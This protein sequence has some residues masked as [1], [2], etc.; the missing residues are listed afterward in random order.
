MPIPLDTW[1]ELAAGASVAELAQLAQV[2]RTTAA[3]WRVTGHV[4]HAVT[5]LARFHFHGSLPPCAGPSWRGWRFCRDG[6]LYAPDLARGFGPDEIRS[7]VWFLQW[8]TWRAAAAQRLGR[9][10]IVHLNMP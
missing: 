3:R 8:E 1:I 4:P 5:Q 6:L 10:E 9:R 2:H 7:L